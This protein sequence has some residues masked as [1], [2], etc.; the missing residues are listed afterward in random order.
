MTEPE[1]T[2]FERTFL[3]RFRSNREAGKKVGLAEYLGL[4]PGQE[5]IV[6]REYRRA[7]AELRRGAGI[8]LGRTIA[9]FEQAATALHAAHEVGLVA[10][11]ASISVPRP[12]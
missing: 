7:M 2:K 3:A 9:V 4:F 8:E 12:S 6:A 1:D 10:I 5:E 11:P